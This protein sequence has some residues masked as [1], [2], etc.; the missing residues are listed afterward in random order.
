MATSKAFSLAG[1]HFQGF[2]LSNADNLSKAM[3][4]FVFAS[5]F[6]YQQG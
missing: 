3:H 1:M 4:Q 2:T 5:H 6:K